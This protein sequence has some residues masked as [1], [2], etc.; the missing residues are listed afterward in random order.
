M[1][2]EEVTAAAST[3]RLYAL[4]SPIPSASR[5]KYGHSMTAFESRSELTSSVPTGHA[6]SV[7]NEGE[8]YEMPCSNRN[9]VCQI[10]AQPSPG[11]P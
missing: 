11:P 7:V 5:S 3:T 8:K 2:S 9:L 6:M 4:T 1:A 10:S